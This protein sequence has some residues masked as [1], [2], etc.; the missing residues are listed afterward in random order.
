[1]S[2]EL[3]RKREHFFTE[4]FGACATVL[5]VIG[6]ILNNRLDRNCFYVWIISNAIVLVLHIKSGLWTLGV[7]DAIFIVLAVEG[8]IKWGSH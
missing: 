3:K 4:I 8:L 2:K 7:R 1:M 6:V 5:A